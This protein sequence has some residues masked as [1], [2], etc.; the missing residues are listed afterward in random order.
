M[1]AVERLK[2]ELFKFLNKPLPQNPLPFKKFPRTLRH[3]IDEVARK[4]ANIPVSPESGYLSV[5]WTG[6]RLETH[7]KMGDRFASLHASPYTVYVKYLHPIK[8]DIRSFNGSLNLTQPPIFPP[9][10]QRV[11][12]V[13]KDAVA[14]LD[15]K[16]DA[17]HIQSLWKVKDTFFP[18]YKPNGTPYIGVAVTLPADVDDIVDRIAWR[19][20]AVFSRRKVGKKA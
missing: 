6:I 12:I 8:G 11:R 15:P 7:Y 20:Q 5:N 1:S 3:L 18:Y 14:Y 10:D 19:V 17:I 4:E 16:P 2:K 13:L 9:G